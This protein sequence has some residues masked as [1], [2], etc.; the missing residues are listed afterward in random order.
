MTQDDLEDISGI[1]KER[2]SRMENG[3][4]VMRWSQFVSFITVFTMRAD[5]KDFLLASE[6]IT[7]RLLQ[8][9]QSKDGHVIPDIDIPVSSERSQ[10]FY[11]SLC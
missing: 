10:K 1:S 3:S 8:A 4:I 11:S 9:L 7:P 2:I 6:I 5:T